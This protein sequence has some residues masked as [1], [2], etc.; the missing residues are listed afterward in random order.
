MPV[1]EGQAYYANIT[2][3]NTKYTP[4]YSVNLVVADEVA[5]DFKKRG[6]STKEVDGQQSLVI[7]RKVKRADGG[8]NST[9]RLLDKNKNPVDTTV[10]NGSEVKVQY[11]EWET[12]NSYGTFKGLDL[13]AMQIINLVESNSIPDGAELMAEDEE[14]GDLF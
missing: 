9:P 7:K 11:K 10:G 8:I 6:F 5:A 3:P 14:I 4:V 2:T 1:I 13:Q 12:T